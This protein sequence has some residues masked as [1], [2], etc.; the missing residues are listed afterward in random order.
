MAKKNRG[1]QTQEHVFKREPGKNLPD[2]VSKLISSGTIPTLLQFVANSF[3]ADATQVHIQ[4]RSEE[5]L[6]SITDDGEGMG[7][8]ELSA[9]YR[10]GDSL[11]VVKPISP[12]GRE[13]IG[14]FGV[15]TMGL[16]TLAGSYTLETWRDGTKI[17]VEESLFGWGNRL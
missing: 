13:R 10:L 8:P 7:L 17:L 14:K 5:R 2:L 9:F 1:D 16:S 15:A 3:D 12:K 4:Y 6:L 11:K